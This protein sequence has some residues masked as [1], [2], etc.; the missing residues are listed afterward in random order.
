MVRL[1]EKRGWRITRLALRISD[2]DSK[3]YSVW[4]EIYWEAEIMDNPGFSTGLVVGS[5]FGHSA[6]VRLLLDKGAD[7][8]SKDKEYGQTPLS[9]AVESGHEAVV[10]LLLDKG[11]NLESKDI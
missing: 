5:Y 4:C 11:A 3:A 10:K 1:A 8:A 2:L 9:W 7:L 6:V